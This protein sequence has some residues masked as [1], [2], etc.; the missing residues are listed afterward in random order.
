MVKSLCYYNLN[1]VPYGNEVVGKYCFVTP[2]VAPN[3]SGGAVVVFPGGGYNHLSNDSKKLG[4][5]NLGEQKEASDIAEWFHPA[6][7]S[8]FVVNYRTRAVQSDVSY[9]TLLAD[10]FRA[11]RFVR[12][13][14]SQWGVDS[15]KIVVM[16]SSAGA[17]LAA[18]LLTL[19]D[20][21]VDD[22]KYQPDEIDSV[23]ANA[24]AGVFAYGVLSFADHFTHIVSRSIFTHNDITLYKKYSPELNVNANTPPCFVW[25]EE[26]DEAVPSACSYVFCQALERCGVPFE[27]HIFRDQ[28][29]KLHGIGVAK[30]FTEARVWPILA[31]NFLKNLGL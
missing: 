15:N 4:M 14:A 19:T 30:D 21:K 17:H 2:Y 27:R 11:L 3:P 31:T 1:N 25:H 23:N 16:G 13:N 5:D 18:S 26:G 28:S 8:I 22:S 7:I 20:W 9:K 24:C 12:A 29:P 10:G 6:G